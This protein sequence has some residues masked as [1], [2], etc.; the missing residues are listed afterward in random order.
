[1][2]RREDFRERKAIPESTVPAPSNE[3]TKP[4]VPIKIGAVGFSHR[5]EQKRS[6]K[7]P[8]GI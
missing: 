2:I 5:T 4:T 8:S 3:Q 6:S 7:T 1:M